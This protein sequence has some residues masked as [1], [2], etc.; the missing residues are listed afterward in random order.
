VVGLSYLAGITA[1]TPGVDM[2]E[3]SATPIPPEPG[4]DSAI[5]TGAQVPS[6]NGEA[7]AEPAT[8]HL[9]FSDWRGKDLIDRDGER[10]GKLED[11][12]F[13]I[14]TDQPEFGTVK[15]GLFERHLT[16]VPL[17][18]IFA[19]PD[20]LQ[21]GV[22]RAQVKK[23]PQIETGGELSQ[24]DE[25]SLYHYYELNYTPSTSPSARRLARR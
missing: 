21:V 23:A 25:S 15:G 11:V 20:N 14:E 8:A 3:A 22:T 19:G 13:D 10:I 17:N 16:F 2:T 1:S 4:D 18:H 7:S 12:Y 6:D 24:A 9:D 5:S